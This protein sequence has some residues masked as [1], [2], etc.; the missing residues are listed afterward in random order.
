M[1]HEARWMRVGAAFCVAAAILGCG[2]EAADNALTQVAGQIE[3]S[4]AG[5]Q[6]RGGG[7]DVGPPGDPGGPPPEDP[8]GL[9]DEQKEQA[10]A[11]FQAAQEDI[12]ALREEAREE[13]RALLTDEQLAIF[14][15][16][17][18]P[19]PPGGHRPPPDANLPPGA[20]APQG[21]PPDGQGGPGGPPPLP[22]C[23]S[24][25]P[26]EDPN[27]PQ[28]PP[29][30]DRLIELLSLTDDQIAAMETIFADTKAAVDAVKDQA[31]ADFRA[32]LTDEQLE[33]LDQ[34]PPP[35]P[36]GQGHG[37]GGH[38]GPPPGDGGG[39]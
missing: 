2:I 18:P 15:E 38:H 1:C 33:I 39:F 3:G 9:T 12:Q 36:P 6:V 26:P 24:V 31:C 28:G 20:N 21:P 5:V 14:D 17:P 29:G 22:Y 23:G 37:H 10:G 4:S 27:A 8:L 7:A 32:I 13:M 25:A 34:M 16:L 35:P 30:F 19:P 11:I